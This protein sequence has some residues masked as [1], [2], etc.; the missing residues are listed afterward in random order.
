LDGQADPIFRRNTVHPQVLPQVFQGT[1]QL[2]FDRQFRRFAPFGVQNMV[3]L[4]QN[5]R[6][7]SKVS[8]FTPYSR[9]KR[10][11]LAS[12]AFFPLLMLSL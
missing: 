3:F 7:F 10:T 9:L 11:V 4:L 5:Q 6:H 1:I 12:A 2:V 8:G